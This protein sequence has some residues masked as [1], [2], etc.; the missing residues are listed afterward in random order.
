[1][2][3]R[4]DVNPYINAIQRALAVGD[5]AAAHRMHDVFAAMATSRAEHWWVHHLG[6]VIQRALLQAEPI[7]RLSGWRRHG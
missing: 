3:M 1:M 2:H 7:D 6:N 4:Y 5:T